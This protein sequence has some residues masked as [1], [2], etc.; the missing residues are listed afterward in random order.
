[1]KIKPTTKN[2][3]IVKEM[4]KIARIS[5]AV[6]A[7]A[8]LA[9]TSGVSSFAATGAITAASASA[10]KEDATMKTRLTTVKERID[11]PEDLTMRKPTGIFCRIWTN[12]PGM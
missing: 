1:M 6:M 11:I 5:A 8:I 2:E 7:A 4:K 12:S 9:S 3:R 10:Q